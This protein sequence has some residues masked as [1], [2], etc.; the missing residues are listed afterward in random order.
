MITV[1]SFSNFD[2]TQL[3]CPRNRSFSPLSQ[4]FS[5]LPIEDSTVDIEVDDETNTD[6]TPLHPAFIPAIT[7]KNSKKA[8]HTGK[9]CSVNKPAAQ[10]ST[11]TAPHFH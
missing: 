10:P 4:L 6:S 1:K 3:A 9:P 7:R 2:R 11:S 8:K 5:S